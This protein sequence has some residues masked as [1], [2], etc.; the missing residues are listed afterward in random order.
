MLT[1]L[2]SLVLGSGGDCNDCKETKKCPSCNGTKVHPDSEMAA[3]GIDCPSCRET[4]G[5]CAH[6]FSQKITRG[7]VEKDINQMVKEGAEK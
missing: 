2:C 3:E 4:D 7:I 5:I 1:R 6:Y